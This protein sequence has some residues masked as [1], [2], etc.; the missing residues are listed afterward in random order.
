MSI[1]SLISAIQVAALNHKK[2]K[3]VLIASAPNQK[4]DLGYPLVRLWPDGF[5]L[6][7]TGKLI[8]Y[9]FALAVLDRAGEEFTAQIDSASDTAQILIDIVATLE[10]IYRESPGEWVVDA[11]ADFV[12][13]ADTDI[14]VGHIVEIRRKEQYK[15]NFCDVPSCDFDFPAIN[16]TNES[17]IDEGGP[18]ATYTSILTITE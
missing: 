9:R 8:Y 6:S 11:T 7:N 17:V 14:C 15:R 4:G 12:N 5:N 10:Y 1:N 18:D 3:Q 16:L 13:D 2:V